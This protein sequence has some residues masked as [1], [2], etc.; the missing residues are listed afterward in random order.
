MVQDEILFG[1]YTIYDRFVND[2]IS[3]AS[4]LFTSL[5]MC[6]RVFLG[7]F[8]RLFI[9]LFFVFIERRHLRCSNQNT[10]FKRN[11]IDKIRVSQEKRI[12]QHCPN[13]K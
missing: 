11:R 12:T 3:C 8:L 9:Y 1:I 6:G 2:Y 13:R 4:R 7:F 5:L 10:I